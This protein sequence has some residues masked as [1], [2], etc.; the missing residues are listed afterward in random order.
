MM[1][2]VILACLLFVLDF[3]SCFS[4]NNIPSFIGPT[5]NRQHQ[6]ADG[7]Y[8]YSLPRLLAAKSSDEDGVPR[9]AP[10]SRLEGNMRKPTAQELKIMDE[11]IMKLA[12]AKP[13]ELP[14]AVRRAAVYLL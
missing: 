10:R 13:Y 2:P 14:N 4:P 12:D 5:E 11:M 6:V 9:A 8:Y 1:L 7:S 3:G